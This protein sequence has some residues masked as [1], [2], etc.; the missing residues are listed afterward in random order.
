M[1]TL[2]R[3]SPVR[4]LLAAAAVAALAAVSTPAHAAYNCVLDDENADVCVQ[5]T[6][7]QDVCVLKPGVRFVCYAGFS[8]ERYCRIVRELSVEVG[9]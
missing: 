9:G 4:R 3:S 8:G 1:P 6:R 2:E 5:V 7:C